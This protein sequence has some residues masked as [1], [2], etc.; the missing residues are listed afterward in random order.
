M[1]SE[2]LKCIF[3]DK[4]LISTRGNVYWCKNHINFYY[5]CDKNE[6]IIKGVIY[7]IK[8]M[9]KLVKLKAFW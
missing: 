2:T 5:N 9:E 3:C 8:E 7:S 1:I 4:Y 6:W